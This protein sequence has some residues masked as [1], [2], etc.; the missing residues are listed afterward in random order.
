LILTFSA[1]LSIFILVAAQVKTPHYAFYAQTWDGTGGG[2]DYRQSNLAYYLV[3]VPDGTRVFQDDALYANM[4]LI[5]PDGQRAITTGTSEHPLL[6]VTNIWDGTQQTITVDRQVRRPFMWSP[7]SKY[8]TVGVIAPPCNCDTGYPLELGVVE[9][10]TGELRVLTDGEFLAGDFGTILWSPDGRFIIYI[11]EYFGGDTGKN[12]EIIKIIP[13]DGSQPPR[14]LYTFATEGEWVRPFMYWLPD[15]KHIALLERMGT[16]EIW[17][18][19]VQTAQISFHTFYFDYVD[20]CWSTVTSHFIAASMTRFK[21]VAMDPSQPLDVSFV[22]PSVW[23]L[24]A[25][26]IMPCSWSP[27]GTK[28]VL[29]YQTSTPDHHVPPGVKVIDFVQRQVSDIEVGVDT[30][31]W[32]PYWSHDSR[33]L[34]LRS[35]QPSRA[36]N[37]VYIYDTVTMQQVLA[38]TDLEFKAWIANPLSP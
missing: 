22:D 10:A 19:D 33:M 14:I 4:G 38:Q 34:A 11:E 29:I 3:S 21:L 36:P 24:S 6:S 2:K 8:F 18:V 13:V 20:I 1:F 32:T 5:S 30:S 35:Y 15:G 26:S 9:V 23:T 7:D 16:S 25:G 27:D 17:V 28:L 31:F 12:Q 37:D